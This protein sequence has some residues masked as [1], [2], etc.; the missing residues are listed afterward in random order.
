MIIE[1][2]RLFLALQTQ[3]TRQEMKEFISE[4]PVP[5]QRDKTSHIKNL[6]HIQIGSTLLIPT[7]LYNH[8]AVN[9]T[10]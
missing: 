9:V 8:S 10:S 3:E 2:P 6:I 1:M 4:E 5:P 7:S